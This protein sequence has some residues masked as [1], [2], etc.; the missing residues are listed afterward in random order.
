MPVKAFKRCVLWLLF[1]NFLF[2]VPVRAQYF[3]FSVNRKKITIPFHQVRDL[4]IIKLMINDKGP[5]NFI[6]DTGVGMMIIT[7]PQLLDSLNLVR[8]R[9][10]N[11]RGLGEGEGYEAYVSPALKI[12]IPGLTSYNVQAAILKK[13][14]FGIS[15]YAGMPI[16]GLLGYE[17]FSNLAVK[18]NFGD[19]TLTVYRP[20]D[21]KLFGKGEKIPIS[22]EDHKPFFETSACLANGCTKKIKLVI[23]LGAGH[24]LSLENM[25]NR[26][27]LPE[28]AILAN[29]G[30][31]FNGPIDG[32][33][34]RIGEIQLGK[35]KIKN[36]I[37]CF[38]KDDSIC[39][40][41]Y[42]KRDG[43]MG[44]GLLKKF[45]VVFDYADSVMYLKPG[46][47][48]DQP[49]EHDMSGLQYYADGD[50]YKRII[51]SQ[52]EPGSAGDKV[53]LEKDDEIL[54]INL[55]PIAK[56]SLEE[57]DGIFKSQNNRSLLLE[58]AHDKKSDMVMLT[59]KRRI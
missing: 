15:N 52:V 41:E 17:F 25:T 24:P 4:V 36:P 21:A 12:N 16:H 29:L 2:L 20:K 39:R 26:F 42:V 49:F 19:S 10:I 18:I 22:I 33:M 50:D 35:Y 5:F 13:D 31:G 46:R 53:G 56:M 7:D 58:V 47:N 23:D 44:M 45:I 1:F 34:C 57:I 27:D 9:L 3:D 6:M 40:H 54:S 14:N 37:S 8:R 32:Y 28:K 59:L 55:K 11:L 38:P 30:M 51:I 48:F 43:N